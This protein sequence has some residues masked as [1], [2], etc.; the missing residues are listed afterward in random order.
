MI[1]HSFQDEAR[2]FGRYLLG[3]DPS[4]AAVALYVEASH[5]RPFTIHP[6][7]ADLIRLGVESPWM[8]GALDGALAF[9]PKRSAL[10]DKLLLMTAILETQ[11]EHA[12]LFLPQARPRGYWLVVGL[13][14]AGAAGRLLYG[15]IVLALL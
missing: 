8:L 6:G 3:H 7:D 10:R 14:L 13:Q 2:A 15:K 5:K 4:A 12:D 9:P 1:G 11:P